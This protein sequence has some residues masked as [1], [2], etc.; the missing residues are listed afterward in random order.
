MIFVAQGSKGER[1]GK[2]LHYAAIW[3]AKVGRSISVN[4]REV[5]AVHGGVM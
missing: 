3:V 1:R 4:S 2:I 5:W